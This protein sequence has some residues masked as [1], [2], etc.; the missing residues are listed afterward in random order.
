M[1]GVL[2]FAPAQYACTAQPRRAQ[3]VQPRLPAA[4][5]A[6]AASMAGRGRSRG[7]G[8]GGAMGGPTARD[9][10]GNLLEAASPPKLFPVR[11]HRSSCSDASCAELSLHTWRCSRPHWQRA[12][13]TVPPHN[14]RPDVC[15]TLC[16][17]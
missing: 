17:W 16:R 11:R 7:R 5:T 10:E 1:T 14:N 8:R 3:G 6:A 2:S 12:H 13:C 4:L 9:D 15:M